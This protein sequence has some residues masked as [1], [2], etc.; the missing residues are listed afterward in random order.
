[1]DILSY[2]SAGASPSR[3]MTNRVRFAMFSI[4]FLAIASMSAFSES[5]PSAAQLQQNMIWPASQPEGQQ[6]YVA[7]RKTFELKEKPAAAALY[8]F[9][10]SRYILWINGQYVERGPCRFDP[11]APEYDT[12]D[13]TRFLRAGPNVV[14]A[15]VHHYHDGRKTDDPE[16]LNGRTMRHAPGWTALLEITK[17][18]GEKAEI[19]TDARWRCSAK[20][21]FLASPVSWGNIPDNIDARLDTGDWTQPEF[22]D[23][24]WETPAPVDGAMWGPLK[25]RAIPLLREEAIIPEMDL[26]ITLV[27]KQEKLLDVGQMA[28]AYDV[29]DMEAEEG[30]EVEVIHGHGCV[31]GKLDEVYGS[32]RYI[33]RAGRQTYMSGDTIGFRYMMIRVHSGK[34][35]LHGIKVVNRLYPFERMGKYLCNDAFLNELWERSV[36]TIQLCSEDGYVDCTARER[37]EWMGDAALSEYPVTRVAFA[38][39]NRDGSYRYSDPLLIRNMLRHIAQSQQPDGRLKAHHPSNR[40]DIH[41]YIDDYACLWVQTLRRYYENTGDLDEVRALWPNLVKQM[42]WFLDRR[43]ERGLVKGR[44]FV[45]FDNP[46]SY[47]ECEGA[48]LNAY[49]YGALNHAA[50]LGDAL[51]ENEIAGK[52]LADAEKLKYDFDQHLWDESKGAYSGGFLD[53]NKT[54]PSAFPAMTG[55]YFGIIPEERKAAVLGYLVNHRD[56]VKTPYSYSLLFDVL[57]RADTPELDIIALKDMR[58]R[59]ASTLA[60]KDLDTVFEGFGGA[61]YC[62]NIGA[63][64][65][66]YMS[67]YVL[68]VRREGMVTD[69]SIIIEPHLGDLTLAEGTVVTELG[70]VHVAWERTPK[71]GSLRF[72]F[73]V[74]EGAKAELALPA[75]KPGLHVT[76]DG[77]A[78]AEDGITKRGNRVV[79][80]VGAGHHTGTLN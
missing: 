70:P 11:Q 40:W 8:C 51:G 28:L 76:L 45:F 36:R 57:Y 63:T 15:V 19:I 12:L 42:Q 2:G 47:K 1:M 56:Q 14:A 3:T 46:L 65:A 74:P 75:V 67:A 33:A 44:E 60:R 53:G 73:Q 7:F 20:T 62:H 59:W 71:T 9:A 43:T 77:N 30:S 13:V 32:N 6:A 34:V 50:A 17:V 66:Y 27:A 25:P 68:G 22:D 72:M 24:Q 4:A 55:L 35:M 37:T 39:K 54:E 80:V 48:T 29:L 64:P 23:A 16:P 21:R 31:E 61:S 38:V 69:K 49:V 18:D 52:Y 58:E 5:S 10:D 78:V 26:P 41:G 79:M